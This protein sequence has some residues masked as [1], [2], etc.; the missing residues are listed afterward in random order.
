MQIKREHH[1]TFWYVIIAVL[2]VTLIQD[3]LLQAAQTKIIPYSEFQQRLD[4]DELTDLVVGQT[5]ITGTFK[6]AKPN[7]PKQFTTFR[8]PPE[9]AQA[10]RRQVTFSGGAAPGMLIPC[11]AGSSRRWV[12]AAVDVHGPARWPA[13]AASAA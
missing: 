3:F 8:V 11:S 5:R 1:V 7:E 13:R 9:L 12:S 6:D 4:Q 2:A 10:V